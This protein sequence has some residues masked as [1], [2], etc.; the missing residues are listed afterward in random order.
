MVWCR[1]WQS[2][3]SWPSDSGKCWCY[4]ALSEPEMFFLRIIQDLCGESSIV[5]WYVH[6][7]W[8]ISG[9][10]HFEEGS[11]SL[12]QRN[13]WWIHGRCN[14]S[15]TCF[16]H[17]PLSGL[18]HSPFLAV[19]IV[20]TGVNVFMYTKKLA[21]FLGVHGIAAMMTSKPDRRGDHFAVWKSVSAGFALILPATAIVIG[22]KI[23]RT[24]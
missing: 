23:M 13:L 18:F 2:Y 21:V 9:K 5:A 14:V 20:R 10:K 15:Y 7:A 12:W 17:N 24:A 19:G 1:Y 6:Y 16:C 22:D 4:K 3:S 11:S 8:K